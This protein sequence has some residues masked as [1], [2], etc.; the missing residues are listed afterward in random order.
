MNPSVQ[1]FQRLLGALEKWFS[2]SCFLFEKEQFPEALETQSRCQL[3][4]NEIAVLLQQPQVRASVDGELQVRTTRLLKK[5]HEES[6]KF[7]FQKNRLHD[8][9]NSLRAT[10]TR[11]KT[12]RHTY[13]SQGE[14]TFNAAFAN[15][16]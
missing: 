1:R 2:E 10:Q 7:S 3:A 13:G 11:A 16:A 6:A 5:Y 14:F 9:L 8:R 4:I 15:Q 12:L